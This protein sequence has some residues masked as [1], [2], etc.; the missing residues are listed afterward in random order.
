MAVPIVVGELVGSP[1]VGSPESPGSS[2]SCCSQD[3]S[4]G[5][6]ARRR[7]LLLLLLVSNDLRSESCLYSWITLSLDYQR[8]APSSHAKSVKVIFQRIA[9]V[10]IEFNGQHVHVRVELSVF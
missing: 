8:P 1:V 4:A 9:T 5:Q 7:L 2:Y 10:A 6:R 3:L